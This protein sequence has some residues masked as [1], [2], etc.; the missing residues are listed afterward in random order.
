MN[1]ARSFAQFMEDEGYGTFGTDIFV[2]SAPLDR[3]DDIWWL[4]PTGGNSIITNQTGEKMKVYTVNVFYRNSVAADVYDALQEFEE[5]VNSD[6]CSQLQGFD[7]IDLEATQ[8]GADQDIDDQER[9]VGLV[10]VTIQ[11]YL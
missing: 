4:V 5:L 10:Q 1:I 6:A 3:E 7:T 11:T 2:G 9:T 8:F